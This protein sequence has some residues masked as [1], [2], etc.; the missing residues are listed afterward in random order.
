MQITTRARIWE[1]DA[2]FCWMGNFWL[3]RDE[4]SFSSNWG[5]AYLHLLPL[6]LE[7][8]ARSSCRTTPSANWRHRNEIVRLLDQGNNCWGLLNTKLPAHLIVTYPSSHS[9]FPSISQSLYSGMQ[10]PHPGKTSNSLQSQS[11]FLVPFVPP[12]SSSLAFVS[13]C[14]QTP[15]SFLHSYFSLPAHILSQT[16][17]INH[18]IGF[19]SHSSCLQHPSRKHCSFSLT[20]TVIC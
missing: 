14:P 4:A 19:L 6:L 12:S 18:P 13:S 2:I 10:K 16:L 3:Q 8:W 20:E 11:S 5:S 1:Q 7:C 15:G 9:A 17:H